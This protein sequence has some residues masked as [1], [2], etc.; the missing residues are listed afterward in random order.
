LCSL[1]GL[2]VGDILKIKFDFTLG[3]DTGS[4]PRSF[5][6][7][8]PTLLWCFRSKG[9]DWNV[10]F[11]QQII[12]AGCIEVIQFELEDISVWIADCESELFIPKWV[13]CF[14]N[15]LRLLRV[16]IIFE[17]NFNV[18]EE[19]VNLKPERSGAHGS[20]FPPKS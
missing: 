20:L 19:R 4:G 2:L 3:R 5:L 8:L 13:Q 7:L 6:K 14:L 11:T 15:G 10:N 12:V 9:R 16:R 1:G 18:A 17:P